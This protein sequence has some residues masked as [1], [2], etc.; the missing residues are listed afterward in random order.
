MLEVRNEAED[1]KQTLRRL[2]IQHLHLSLGHDEAPMIG[3]MEQVVEWMLSEVAR[4]T[5]L[6]IHCDDGRQRSALIAEA[7]LV[8][9]GFPL[10]V[11][12]EFLRRAQPQAR[13]SIEQQ[14]TLEVFA[15]YRLRR[16]EA[17]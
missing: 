10:K 15:A 13:L 5:K 1:D 6:L 8:A 16:R 7:V 9:L 2:G 17:A 3:E 11:A 14:Y 12:D 4:G